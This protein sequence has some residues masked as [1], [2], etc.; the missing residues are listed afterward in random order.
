MTSDIETDANTSDV[1]SRPPVGNL[2]RVASISEPW[3]AKPSHNPG[4]TNGQLLFHV[5][6]G[7]VLV[8]P[9][10][11]ILVFFGHLLPWVRESLLRSSTSR[12]RSST[13]LTRWALA[14]EPVCLAGRASSASSTKAW[15]HSNG[16]SACARATGRWLC[17]TRPVGT[18]A[19]RRP[20]TWRTSSAIRLT[21]FGITDIS[22]GPPMRTRQAR[23]PARTPYAGVPTRT[24]AAAGGGLRK[25]VTVIANWST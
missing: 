10:A 4:W 19:S 18:R 15:D 13:G 7:F 6:L 17:T 16:S 22:C 8:L 5:L 24:P 21:T 20:C 23:R 14:P 25:Y 9:L 11:G 1:S 3:W 12:L 2:T